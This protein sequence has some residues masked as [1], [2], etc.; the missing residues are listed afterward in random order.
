MRSF[1]NTH[2][3]CLPPQHQVSIPTD[4]MDDDA[5]DQPV[6]QPVEPPT[7]KAPRMVSRPKPPPQ[8]E[9][10]LG[11]DMNLG[12]F[13]GEQPLSIS[14]A[15]ILIT[16]VHDKRRQKAREGQGVLGDRAHNDNQ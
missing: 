15:R 8:Q 3:D 4:A 7:F 5:H 10:G 9:E 16:A 2:K 12:S 1:T 14:E 13:E 6:H 11:N